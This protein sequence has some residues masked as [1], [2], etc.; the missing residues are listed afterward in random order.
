MKFSESIGK[1]IDKMHVVESLP[2]SMCKN[3]LKIPVSE[4]VESWK[5]DNGNII[6]AHYVTGRSQGTCFLIFY[7][8][9]LK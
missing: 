8:L 6:K 1:A 7:K 2:A 3:E 9:E 5:N 4:Y